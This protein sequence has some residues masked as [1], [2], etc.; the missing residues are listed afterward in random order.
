MADTPPT[1][2]GAKRKREDDLQRMSLEH[3]QSRRL[4]FIEG[5]VWVAETMTISDGAAVLRKL[6]RRFDRRDV[7]RSCRDRG[8]DLDVLVPGAV[9]CEHEWIRPDDSETFRWEGYAVCTRCGELRPPE[10]A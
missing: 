7:A 2:K 10:G 5:A 3:G 4:G 1:P 9:P 6:L 8:L